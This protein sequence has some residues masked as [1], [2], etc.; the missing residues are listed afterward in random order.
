MFTKVFNQLLIKNYPM[1]RQILIKNIFLIKNSSILILN[2]N[3]KLLKR[4]DEV[5]SE[6]IVMDKLLQLC[7]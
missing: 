2:N 3:S 6:S 5:F 7:I 4:F 1:D